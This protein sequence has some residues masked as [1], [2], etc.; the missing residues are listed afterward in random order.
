M[1]ARP[2]LRV[3]AVL[4]GGRAAFRGSLVLSA[5]VL[6]AIW[7]DPAFAPYAVAVGTTLVLSPLVGSGA[8]K[9][10]GMLLAR[11]E[12]GGGERNSPRVLAA[13]VTIVVVIASASMLA[14][15]PLLMRLP[16]PTDL[17]VLA[18]LTNVGFGAVQA[19]VAYWRVLG[20]PYVDSLSHSTLAVATVVGVLLA[21]FADAGPQTVLAIQGS[22]ALAVA[23][24]LGL[25]LRHRLARPRR[26]DLVVTTR[27]T[28]LMGANTLLATAA[29]SVVFAILAQQ[30]LTTAAGQLYVAIVGYT[31]VANLFDYLLRVFQPWLAVRL[32]DGGPA[33][34]RTAGQVARFSLLALV[35]LSVGA[36]LM[37]SRWVSGTA[38][39]LLV[40]AAV[41][42]ALLVAAALVWVL[43]N[44]DHATLLGT[45]L[46]GILGLLTTV[47]AGWVLLPSSPVAGSALV[48]LAGAAVTTAALLPMLRRRVSNVLVGQ[49]LLS[50]LGRRS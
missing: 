19:L 43:E 42:P 46:A 34:V 44:L 25:A 2:R 16:G 32:A 6:L 27:T 3:V 7:G 29:V 8:E 17:Y 28:V 15:V 36:V 11:A 18:A 13:H 20:R 12:A 48:L 1:T 14:A 50:T 38:E 37:S 9:S 30:G 49:P 39:A 41:T 10:A 45:V 5:P 47:I 21:A 24:G 23:A 40:V 22:V 4:L 35:P 31:V 26:R 33:M